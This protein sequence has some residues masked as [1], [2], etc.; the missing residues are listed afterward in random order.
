MTT[1]LLTMLIFHVLLGLAALL[2]YGAMWLGINKRE[3]DVYRQRQWSLWGLLL[4]VLSWLTGGY[5]YVSYYGTAVK[6][7]IQKGLAPWAHSV[8]MEAKEHVFLFLP[9]IA[10]V[11]AIM[12][13]ETP[14]LEAG[15]AQRRWLSWLVGIILLLGTFVTLSG[16]VI[17]GAVR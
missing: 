5:Y 9:F 13:M 10:A 15:H 17:S 7:I 6:P 16:L 4:L 8:F 2:F 14:D 12:L 11:V 3:P 1:T